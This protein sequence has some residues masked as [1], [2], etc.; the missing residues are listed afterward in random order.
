SVSDRRI[1]DVSLLGLYQ[2]PELRTPNHQWIRLLVEDVM[3]RVAEGVLIFQLALGAAGGPPRFGQRFAKPAIESTR[4]VGL[5]IGQDLTRSRVGRDLDDKMEMV[6]HDGDGAEKP[7]PMVCGFLKLRQNHVCLF[8]IKE[9]RL[10][11]HLFS[12]APSQSR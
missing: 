11:F 9:N 3:D 7:D 2:A 8:A 4:G 10:P 6:G 5:E 1:P 12:S